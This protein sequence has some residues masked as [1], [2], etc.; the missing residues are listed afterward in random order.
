MRRTRKRTAGFSLM[1]TIALLIILT[2]AVTALVPAM[3]RVVAGR[4]ARD[5]RKHM[6]AIFKGLVGAPDEGYFGFVGDLGRL[7]T[8][9][10]DLAEAGDWPAYTLETVGK[11]GVG[12]DGPYVT[13]R[14][15]DLLT[16]AWGNN[17]D[18]GVKVPGQIRSAGPDG[19]LDTDDDIVYPDQ[20]PKYYGTLTLEL[21]ND[22]DFVLRLYY[23]DGGKQAC[24]DAGAAP[25]IFEKVHYGSHPVQIWLRKSADEMQL[26]SE[27]V[28]VLAHP[29]RTV[30][31]NK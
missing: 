26:V 18:F 7:P 19:E 13:L 22:G 6:E 16:D 27:K 8:E 25:Y 4:K 12:W 1:E 5:T 15:E 11:V 31:L 28:V 10:K 14:R 24:V 3:Y 20:E 9:L 17:Y 21:M 29:K 2:I 23:S 30:V